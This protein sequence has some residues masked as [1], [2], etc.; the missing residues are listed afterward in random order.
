MVDS[1]LNP[2]SI[3]EAVVGAILVTAAVLL[4]P[5][6]RLWYYKWGA[7]GV[8]VQWGL[9]GDYLVPHP[10][11]TYTRAITIR[12][13]ASRVWLLLTQIWYHG[14]G[15]QPCDLLRGQGAAADSRDVTSTERIVSELQNLKVG[16]KVDLP[17]Q[18]GSYELAAVEPGRALVLLSRIDTKTGNRYE[19]ADPVP[20]KY[21]ESS[22]VWYLRR[23]DQQTTRLTVRTRLDYDPSLRSMLIWRGLGET[24]R[25]VIERSVL[26]AIKQRAEAAA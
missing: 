8:E 12:A 24:I 13:S 16:D 5:V 7:T 1:Q 14:I 26:L 25:L 4:S 2:K 6:I 17:P 20:E 18:V 10:K 22:W 23:V 3:G 15:W 11:L 21:I 19:Q 9:P